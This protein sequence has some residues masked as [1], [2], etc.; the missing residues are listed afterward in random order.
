MRKS[1]KVLGLM[2]TAAMTASMFAGCGGGNDDEN[3]TPTTAGN[4]GDTK[5]IGRASCR[6]RV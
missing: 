3:P 4:Q 1:K 5:E 2:L 6:E